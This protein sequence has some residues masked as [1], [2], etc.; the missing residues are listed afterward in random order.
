MAFFTV[1]NHTTDPVSVQEREDG[2]IDILVG[3]PDAAEPDD[4]GE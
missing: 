2:V 4:N 3:T 1:V